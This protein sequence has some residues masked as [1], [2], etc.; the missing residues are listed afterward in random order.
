MADRVVSFQAT[1]YD[2]NGVISSNLTTFD[3]FVFQ[4]SELPASLD[5]ELAILDQKTY[6]KYLKL[7]NS[8]VDVVRFLPPTGR[9]CQL[10]PSAHSGSFWL[11]R[12]SS[13]KGVA[14]VV[15]LIMLSVIT[16]IV[17]A[18]LAVAR[19]ERSAVTQSTYT[20]TAKYMA[21]TG[22]ERAKALIFSQIIA[23]TNLLETRPGR[24]AQLHQPAGICRGK[25]RLYQRELCLSKQHERAIAKRFPPKPEQPAL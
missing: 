2:R 24:L 23:T 14:L 19:R 25:V 13:Q 4:G 10:I 20:A 8:Y 16:V 17:V 1:P 12:R 9:S 7:T 6:L 21:D 18:F 11:M 5:L 15:T 3:E 22:F